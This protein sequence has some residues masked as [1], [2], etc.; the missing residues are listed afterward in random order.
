[1]LQHRAYRLPSKKDVGLTDEQIVRETREAA[2][3]AAALEAI[4]SLFVVLRSNRKA[5]DDDDGR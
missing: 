4:A 3:V 1:M 2:G 5:K